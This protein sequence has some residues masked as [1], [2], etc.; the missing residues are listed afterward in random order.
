MILS[1]VFIVLSLCAIT[2]SAK[3]TPKP[4][5]ATCSPNCPPSGSLLP[6]GKKCTPC[7]PPNAAKVSA[8]GD[9]HVSVKLAR[10][11]LDRPVCYDLIGEPGDTLRLYEV[12]DLKVDAQLISSPRRGHRNS[13]YFGSF[14][15]TIG[16]HKIEMTPASVTIHNGAVTSEVVP[17]HP[18]VSKAHPVFYADDR[19]EI[20]H[21]KRKVIRVNFDGTRFE[22]KRNLLKY[23]VKKGVK[24]NFDF[25]GIYLEK[26]DPSVTYSG[27]IGESLSAVAVHSTV[28]DQNQLTI[29][30]TTKATINVTDAQRYDYLNDRT[31][32]CW[33]ISDLRVLLKNKYDSYKV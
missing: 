20:V 12:G 5:R 1:A 8:D 30:D 27:I 22:I 14:I 3:P 19:L 21:W 26:E 24:R 11:K 4:K 25:L 2:A 28:G 7:S 18:W 33:M 10:S 32:S 16:D 13:K 23:G 29:G 15:F 17:W 31:Y 6:P 9:P